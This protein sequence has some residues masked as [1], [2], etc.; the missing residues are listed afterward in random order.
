MALRLQ[1]F[2]PYMHTDGRVLGI[3]PIAPTTYTGSETSVTVSS[4]V[5]PTRRV[6]Y[7]PITRGNP[8]AEMDFLAIS[9][10]PT[11]FRRN[12]QDRPYH[13]E[14]VITR[15]RWY[16]GQ[17]IQF[18]TAV[19]GDLDFWLLGGAKTA[20]GS[21]VIPPAPSGSAVSR[22]WSANSPFAN[23][24]Y[25][26]FF[27]INWQLLSGI[28]QADRIQQVTIGAPSADPG[29]GAA[30]KAVL[31]SPANMG[32]ASGVYTDVRVIRLTKGSPV[33]AGTYTWPL[34]VRDI[35]NQTVSINVSVV[36]A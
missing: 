25:C 4:I 16:A 23:T 13:L 15:P 36:V 8:I 28:T 19:P 27:D 14:N 31:I 7:K 22:N 24:P 11:E 3:L 26:Q 1:Y 6:T 5:Y 17:G 21:I 18:K 9:I 20:V 34:T 10:T 30:L 35:D 12:W 32:S 2:L 29:A 33:P